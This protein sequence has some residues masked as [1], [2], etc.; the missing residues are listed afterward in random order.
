MRLVVDTGVFSAALSQRRRPRFEAELATLQGNQLFLAAATVVELRFGAIVAGWG[1]GRRDRLEAAISSTTVVPVS[2]R[3]LTVMAELRA[4][5]RRLGNPLADR[6]HGNDLWIAA[7]A[8]HLGVPLVTA[9][10]VF[11]DVPGLTLA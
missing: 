10:G 11:A 3:F 8:V 5:C 7:T 4:Q 1:R 6:V 9:D 2:D